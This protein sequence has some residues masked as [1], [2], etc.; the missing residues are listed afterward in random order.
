MPSLDFVLPHWL[1]W[2]G[3]LLFPLDRDGTRAA[4]LRTPADREAVAVHR[5][6]L[7][8]AA[9]ASSASIASTCA[10]PG[11][12]VHPGVPRHHLLQRP[13]ARGARRRRRGRSRRCEQ[14]QTAARRGEA[15]RRA[16]AR[17]P[18]A[19][20]E[21][22]EAESRHARRSTTPRRR[23]RP[24]D[25]DAPRASRIVLAV[26]A[27]G[28]RRPAAAAWCGGAARVETRRPPAADG[29]CRGAGGPRAASREDPTLGMRT[30]V[31]RLRSTGSACAPASIVA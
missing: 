20:H 8:G 15:G 18:A 1:Y 14:A 31:H 3:L 4:Q 30:A 23:S 5:L 21:R 26:D 11:A 22:A 2:A 7:P 6:P 19:E 25:S 28:R 9:P 13:G 16:Q 24:L 29:A 12:R 10:A 17:R 27:A